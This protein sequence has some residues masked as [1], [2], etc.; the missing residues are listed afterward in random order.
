MT[1]IVCFKIFLQCIW[2]MFDKITLTPERRTID[3]RK[4]K[5]FKITLIERLSFSLAKLTGT[6]TQRLI[7]GNVDIF[8]QFGSHSEYFARFFQCYHLGSSISSAMQNPSRLSIFSMIE[9]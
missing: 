9:G 7:M 3:I 2:T 6:K 8:S 1:V 4:V 5:I